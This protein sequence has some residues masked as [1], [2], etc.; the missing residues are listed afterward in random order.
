MDLLRRSPWLQRG[1]DHAAVK[2]LNLTMDHRLPFRV[3]RLP[4]REPSS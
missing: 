3:P 4:A 1:L 2:D